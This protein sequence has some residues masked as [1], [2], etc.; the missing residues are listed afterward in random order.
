MSSRRSAEPS[1]RGRPLPRFEGFALPT[2]N[3]LYCPNQFFDVCL[4]HRSRGCVRIVAY[5]LRKT[6]GWCDA[7]GRPQRERFT[8]TYSE[9]EHEAAVSRE[10]IRRAL[11]EAV[12]YRF[13]RCLQ[14]PHAKAANQSALS[15]LYE[16]RWDESDEYVKDASRFN[17]FFAGDGN[18]T[19]VPN[20][21]FDRV[22]PAEPLAIVKVVGSVIRSSIG[23]QTKW[24]H[25]RQQ[26]ALS[27]Q[28]IHRYARIGSRATVTAAI[29]MSIAK[30]YIRR[31]EDGKFDPQ[32][33]RTSKA[34]VYAVQWLSE[35]VDGS[36]D[37]KS[38]PA[39][40][41]FADRSE[42]RTGIGQKT[43]PAD[44]SEKRTDIQ[45]TPTNNTNKQQ[46]QPQLSAAI[47]IKE[48]YD[49]LRAAG[50]DDRTAK[51]LANRYP[52]RRIRR[53]IDWVELRKP[54]RNRLGMLRLAIEQDWARPAAATDSAD[55]SP[56]TSDQQQ[57]IDQ[58]IQQLSHKLSL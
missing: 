56:M 42:N 28:Q 24:G 10:M 20:E 18:R 22:I 3:T 45:I 52:L 46:R 16:L 31:V 37:Q 26:V 13:I 5:M 8:F 12:Q 30:H 53:Q 4:P 29:S 39:K 44:R 1:E 33:G 50:Y 17:G 54:R 57:H 40:S 58:A 47:S 41:E 27:Y 43:V 23:F 7:E 38:V 34:A 6:L 36:I 35:A 2:S 49:F 21:F 32:A 19:Y 9:I 48:G 51:H 14:V 15:G 25:R 11:D 55:P